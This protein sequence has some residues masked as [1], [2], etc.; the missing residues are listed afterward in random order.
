VL[1]LIELAHLI[2]VVLVSFKLAKQVLHRTASGIFLAQ[3]YLSTLLLFAGIYTLLFRF[4]PTGWDQVHLTSSDHPVL[5]YL[6]ML[7]FS[8]STATLCGTSKVEPAFWGAYIAVAI[9][10]LLSFVYFASILSLSLIPTKKSTVKLRE[11]SLTK[12]IRRCCFFWRK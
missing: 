11:R 7:Y 3:C 6:M 4:S 1:C 8:I 2:V 5:V 9:Q 10:M 12:H